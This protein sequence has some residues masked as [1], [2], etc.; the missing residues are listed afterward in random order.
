MRDIRGAPAPSNP[1][2][3]F[4]AAILDTLAAIREELQEMNAELSRIRE[5]QREIAVRQAGAVVS[6]TPAGRGRR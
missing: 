5:Q 1:N 4:L 2:E 3:Q 6:A